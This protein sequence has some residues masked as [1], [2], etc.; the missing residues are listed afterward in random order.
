MAAGIAAE[1]ELAELNE[2]VAYLA[3][4]VARRARAS[5]TRGSVA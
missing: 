3:A 2:V 4:E 5:R 1:A